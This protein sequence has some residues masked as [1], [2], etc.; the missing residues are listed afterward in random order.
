MALYAGGLQGGRLRTSGWQHQSPLWTTHGGSLR[1]HW[2]AYPSCSPIPN[3]KTIAI[4]RKAKTV[5]CGNDAAT[6]SD[7]ERRFPQRL[8][9]VTRKSSV[10]FPH[11]HSHYCWI[12]RCLEQKPK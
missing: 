7:K 10:T 6:E 3:R 1:R 5:G 12:N 2:C 9:K 8:G 4:K 11:S